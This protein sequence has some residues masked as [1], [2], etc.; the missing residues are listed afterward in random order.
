MA[1]SKNTAAQ[2]YEKAVVEEDL[3][4]IDKEDIP[5][6]KYS[7][8]FATPRYED[9]YKVRRIYPYSN[10]AGQT[11]P[12]FSV[13][14]LL[15]AQQ[16]RMFNDVKLPDTP[17]DLS[18]RLKPFSIEDLQYLVLVFIE[19]YFID[20]ETAKS[21]RLLA[22]TLRS[23]ESL[24]KSIDR[25]QLPMQSHSI[26]F[27]TPNKGTNMEVERRYQ[28]AQASGCTLEE[29]MTAFCIGT[30]DGIPVDQPKDIVSIFN[31]WPIVD[32][33]YLVLVFVNTFTMDDNGASKAK[34][35]GKKLRQRCGKSVTGTAG[36]D[37]SQ[38]ALV[39][40]TVT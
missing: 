28:G 5:S 9:Y 11:N 27:H 13:E 22:D 30:V 26:T 23:S 20:S 25:K 33:Q 10:Q 36:N 39:G 8:S 21:A 40:M 2:Q 19:A 7:L 4:T 24:V 3:I 15:I 37:I 6:G 32:V 14:E 34:E 35:L 12:P 1:S 17:Q 38:D 18:E 16:M 31:S 29:M